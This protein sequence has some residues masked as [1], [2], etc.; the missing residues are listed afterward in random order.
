MIK[1]IG[2]FCRKQGMSK[3][4]FVDRYENPEYGHAQFAMKFCPWQEDYRRNHVSAK[5]PISYAHLETS[6]QRPDFDVVMITKAKDMAQAQL[7]ANA[8]ADPVI[9][10]KIAKDE[11]ALFDR[12]KMTIINVDER[13]TPAAEMCP[14]PPGH[15]GEPAL[16]MLGFA[17][18][19]DRSRPR[20]EFIEDYEATLAK[21]VPSL[22]QA[23]DQPI[24]AGYIRNY[25]NHDGFANQ[26]HIEIEPPKAEFDVMNE[27]WFWTED[28]FRN[29]Q[30]ACA[31]PAIGARMGVEQ[32][33][34]LDTSS[35]SMI[36]VDEYIHTRELLDAA[37]AAHAAQGA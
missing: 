32:S 9:G 34:L 2:L 13:A 24:F 18:M 12:T 11:E 17:R 37:L 14:R 10:G 6:L 21:L 30:E 20:D 29:F 4:A 8:L 36:F 33:R 7:T 23:D 28:D 19:A 15:T 25:V 35:I 26:G 22:L 3:E 1:T 27:I 5:P 31:D 16:K